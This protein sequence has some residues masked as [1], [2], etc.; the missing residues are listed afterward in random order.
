MEKT[1]GMIIMII[2]CLFIISCGGSNDSN[3]SLP[4]FASYDDNESFTVINCFSLAEINNELDYFDDNFIDHSWLWKNDEYVLVKITASCYH[5]YFQGY[6]QSHKVLRDFNTVG[7][8]VTKKIVVD[9]TIIHWQHRLSVFNNIIKGNDF[10]IT[11]G[12]FFN[13]NFIHVTLIGIE[14][15]F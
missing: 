9:F 10:Y 12:F 5:P 11:K 3:D 4:F 13:D 1:T 6:M 8:I 14:S 15:N 7:E 2:V